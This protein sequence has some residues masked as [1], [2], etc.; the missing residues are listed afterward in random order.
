MERAFFT[1]SAYTSI[2]KPSGN[3]ILSTGNLEDL[4]SLGPGGLIFPQLKASRGIRTKMGSNRMS[5]FRGNR[6]PASRVGKYPPVYATLLTAV[7]GLQF[8][9]AGWPLAA[10]RISHGDSA[11]PSY[12]GLSRKVGRRQYHGLSKIHKY[13]LPGLQRA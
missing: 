3:W 6:F 5:F 10:L 9:P 7:T 4:K 13:A 8:P 2:S 1:P 11:F 12:H